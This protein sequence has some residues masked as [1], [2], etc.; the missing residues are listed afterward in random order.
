VLVVARSRVR[1][2]ALGLPRRAVLND[3]LAAWIAELIRRHPTFGYRRLW[4]LRRFREGIHFMVKTVYRLCMPKGWFV[5]QRATT[6]RP[7]VLG[8]RSQAA[9]SN[10][11]WATD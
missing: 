7:R 3:P 10:E 6:L 8:L 5:H 11:R 1:R 4:G 2:G 9:G